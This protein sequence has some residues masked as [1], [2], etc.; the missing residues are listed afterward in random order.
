VRLR[1]VEERDLERVRSL[2]NRYRWAFFNDAE[3]SEA[4]QLRWFRT[5][6]RRSVAFYVIEDEG[7]V[8]GTISVAE[9]DRGKEIGNVILDEA[10]RGKGIMSEAIAQLTTGPGPYFAL[11]KPGN[12][13]SLEL[14]R[15]AAFV[16]VHVR[17]ELQAP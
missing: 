12:Q 13:A 9:H 2:R 1:L 8:V 4:E 7:R 10:Y 16:D 3:I 11:V 15:R 14:F 17:L 5:L 6:Q